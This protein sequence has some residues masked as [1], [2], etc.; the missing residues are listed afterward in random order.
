M[1][2]LRFQARTADNIQE[3]TALDAD[4][5]INWMRT[6]PQP[7]LELVGEV[8]A[9]T[10]PKFRDAMIKSLEGDNSDL[11]IVMDRVEYI[12]STGLG[13][14]VGGLKRVSEKDGRISIVCDN[15]QVSKVFE[16][17]GLVKVFPMFRTLEEA[18]AALRRHT[19]SAAA[20]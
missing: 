16:I 19:P 2:H 9:Y 6:E 17:T 4:L 7:V 10:C 20:N 15:P 1:R 8:D 11:I 18:E 13:A 3:V 5:K 12:D 14:L